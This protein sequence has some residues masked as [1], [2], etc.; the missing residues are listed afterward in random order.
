MT[1]LCDSLVQEHEVIERVLDSLERETGAVAG[2]KTVDRAFFADVIKF[3]REFAD[4]VHHQ[5]EETVLFPAL[6]EAGMPKDGGPV[7]V[8]LYEHDEG[9]H[10]IRAM[11]ASLDA[12]ANGEP[13]ARECLVRE[14]CG[15]VELLRA[16]IQKENMIL[17]PMAERLL[18]VDRQVLA[19]QKFTE[20]DQTHAENSARH[21][22]WVAQLRPEPERA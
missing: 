11:E 17:F 19:R 15:Y 21:R 14:S 2:G 9:R 4:G 3:V 1:G 12:A 22:S 13:S 8:M 7:G 10:H 20:A 6:C 18:N 16:H 5:K